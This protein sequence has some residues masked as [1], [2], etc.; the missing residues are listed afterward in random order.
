M[1][2]TLTT[3]LILFLVGLVA[4]AINVIAGGGSLLTLPVMIFM[5]LPPTVANGTNRL[6]ILVESIGATWSFHR[7]RLISREWLFLA[8]PPAIVGA[9][10]GTIAAVNIGDL[11]FQKILAVIMVA[12]A[13]W[14]IWH[15]TDPVVADDS[16][17][18]TGARW[19][20]FVAVFFFIGLYGG[21]IQA[22]VGFVILAATSLA[23]LNLIRG[24]ALKVAV[25]L[26]FTPLALALFAWGGKVDWAIG[27]ALAAGNFLGGLAGVRLQILKGHDW[28]RN[29]VT[30]VIVLFA[31]RLLFGS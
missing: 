29:V 26:A 15:R 1:P 27:V 6:A 14:T 18:P 2:D 19:Y 23:G 16:G 28:V 31:I 17:V 25:V 9:V 11:V 22:G 10:I 3:S 4:G 20:F 30:V 8:L 7:R 24:N 5:G 13:A 12:S 21:F